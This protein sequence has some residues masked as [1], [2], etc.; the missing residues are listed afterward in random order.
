MGPIQAMATTMARTSLVLLYTQSL[1]NTIKM[2]FHFFKLK[3]HRRHLPWFIPQCTNVRLY[4]FTY[5][6]RV[7]LWFGLC[8]KD[9]RTPNC[10]AA[11]PF[12]ARL[13]LSFLL[14]FINPCTSISSL[15][16]LYVCINLRSSLCWFFHFSP[17]RTSVLIKR[18]Q[19]HIW[20]QAESATLFDSRNVPL[21]HCS[22][23]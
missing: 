13:S 20:I 22:L 8:F 18:A 1:S 14:P 23:V 16:C 11:T 10:S 5:V 19:T 21:K 3:P 7:P 15:V 17:P 2:G 9:I 12:S 6:F 4:E